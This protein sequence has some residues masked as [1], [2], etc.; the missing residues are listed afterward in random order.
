[1]QRLLLFVGMGLMISAPLF[2]D[3]ITRRAEEELRKRNLYFGDVDGQMNSELRSALKRYQARKGFE[4]TGEIDQETA[5]SLSITS[6]VSAPASEKRW[7]DLPVLKSDA[8][9]EL[10]EHE[11]RVLTQKAEKTPDF[12][13]PAAPA[14]SPDAGQ[15]LRPEEVTKLVESYLRDAETED[16]GAQVAYYA[17]P[18]E[19]FDH[20]AVSRA[21]VTK[22]TR[23]YVKRWPRR[24]YTLT[25]PVKFFAAEKKSETRVEFIIAFN[26][27]NETHS[28]TGKTRNFWTI[29]P[30]NGAL[31]IVSIREER[32]HQ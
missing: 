20:G 30:E 21:F 10:P 27:K 8:A 18:V 24:K 23:N 29:K 9:R 14:E 16:V 31:K 28:V 26:V 4:V 17:Y 3:E 11:R 5:S 2:A 7:P 6:V 12:S 13:N 1:M 25:Q 22:D 15:D 19:Y 32:L